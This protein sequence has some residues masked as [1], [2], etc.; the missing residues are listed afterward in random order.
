[1]REEIDVGK[2]RNKRRKGRKSRVKKKTHQSVMGILCERTHKWTTNGYL[3]RTL[4]IS[5]HVVTCMLVDVIEQGSV[6]MTSCP[7]WEGNVKYRVLSRCWPDDASLRVRIIEAASELGVTKVVVE[8]LARRVSVGILGYAAER[9]VIRVI[10]AMV[11]ERELVPVFEKAQ[12][13]WL[14][15]Q[16]IYVTVPVNQWLWRTALAQARAGMV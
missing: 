16:Y 15:S 12:R 13:T 3:A 9:A 10:E 4:G 14:D 5:N 8:D 11:Y 6:A 1:M 2:G 7:E